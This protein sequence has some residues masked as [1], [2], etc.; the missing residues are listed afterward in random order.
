MTNDST[1]L[2]GK[3]LAQQL[4]TR[5]IMTAVANGQGAHPVSVIDRIRS[6]TLATMQFLDRGDVSN[7]GDAVWEQTV[8]SLEEEFAAVRNRLVEQNGEPE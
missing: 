5:I 8:A 7:H 4:I 3:I 1:Y 2:E 6:E